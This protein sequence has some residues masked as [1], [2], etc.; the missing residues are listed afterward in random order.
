M[1]LPFDICRCF[2]S[3]CDIKLTCQRFT[4]KAVGAM[5]V[6]YSDNLCLDNE[7]LNTRRDYIEVKENL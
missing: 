5:R 2:A 1:N 3:K 4:D 7:G 6:P